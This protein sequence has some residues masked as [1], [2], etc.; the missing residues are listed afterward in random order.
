LQNP[1]GTTST[2]PL[3]FPLQRKDLSL[4]IV[5]DNEPYVMEVRVFLQNL[6][7][8]HVLQATNNASVP[9][10][11][12]NAAVVYVGPAD[13]NVN[14]AFNDLTNATRMGGSVLMTA[15]TLPT[16][17]GGVIANERNVHTND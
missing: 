15:R 11:S 4:R 10:D 7:M 5:H 6:M 17:K 1:Y 9:S 13:W 8:V 2:E 3:M 12:S 14:H 16:S